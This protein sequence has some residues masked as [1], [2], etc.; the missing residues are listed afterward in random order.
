MKNIVLR[1]AKTEPQGKEKWHAIIS[2][3]LYLWMFLVGFGCWLASLLEL[4]ISGMIVTAVALPVAVLLM[5]LLYGSKKMKYVGLFVWYTLL[6]LVLALFFDT[7]LYGKNLLLNQVMDTIGKQYP[8]FLPEYPV[9]IPEEQYL[10]LATTSYIWM[11]GFISIIGAYLVLAGNRFL[12]GLL[13]LVSLTAQAVS[14]I[15]APFVWNL[16]WLCI[17]AAL[18]FRVHGKKLPKTRIRWASLEQLIPLLFLTVLLVFCICAVKTPDTYEKN[19]AAALGKAAVLSA[20]EEKRYSGDAEILPDGDFENLG[21]FAPENKEVLSVT[22][23]EPESYYLRGFTGSV[24]TGSGWE[25][26][27][28]ETRWEKKSLFYWLHEDGYY[29]QEALALAA[30][31]LGE[32]EEEKNRIE[33]ENVGA[34]SKY[35]YVP[36]ELLDNENELLGLSEQK[37]GDEGLLTLD[38]EG[39]RSYVYQAL[40]N[41]VVNYPSL[42]AKL[43][44]EENL[45][46]EEK[47][48][49]KLESYYNEFVYDTYLDLPQ[50]IKSTLYH[51]LGN[52]EIESGEKHASYTDARQNILYA[53]TSG[54]T[55]SEELAENWNGEDFIYEFLNLSKTGYSVHYASAAVMMFRYYGIPARYVEGYLITPTDV[56]NMTAGQAYI[57]DDAYS[58][59]WVEFYQ[60]GVGW[61]PFEVTPSYL[62]VMEQ[63][64]DYQD[65][66][67]V[68]GELKEEEPEENE[69]DE[70]EEDSEGEDG[71]EIDWLHILEIILLIIIGM[72]LL[73]LLTF[74]LWVL[75]KRRQS[76]KAKK[77]FDD[78]DM[79][80]AISSLFTYSMNILSVSGLRI[81]NV[82]LYRYEKQI[83]HMF[84]EETK[85]A[86]R[87]I[88]DI[89]QEAL[90]SNHEI[91]MEQKEK[92]VQFKDKVWNRI[93]KNGSWIQKLQLKYIYFL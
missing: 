67:G 50:E 11:L 25:E 37:I 61:L 31:A 38:S 57:L 42:A 69:E 12:T 83:C 24:Y 60:D 77:A 46:E 6:A 7:L 92:L 34:S 71:T 41:Q 52:A 86:Y 23:S 16:L 73:L 10:M 15:Y 21:S 51:L 68:V 63:A 35:C 18:W 59:A 13:L 48:Y 4:K 36:Y 87:E 66:S 45:S 85:A 26:T 40:S 5:I 53:L 44:D 49:Q 70:T 3:S 78:P 17:L 82:S 76:R 91:S 56:E 8:Y 33:I 89:R 58:H 14:G 88:V 65:I 84:D 81:R 64:D 19:E 90:Y 43:L 2:D 79:R 27:D 32:T 62:N 47:E 80:T 39:S 72:L 74:I 22:M 29:G 9:M 75:V 20:L 30:D 93:Y 55:Y 1:P 28:S 54:Y